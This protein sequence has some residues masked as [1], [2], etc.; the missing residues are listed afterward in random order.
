MPAAGL[1]QC[2]QTGALDALGTYPTPQDYVGETQFT[3]IPYKF[4]YCLRE[5][6]WLT[7][8][9]VPLL[10]KLIHDGEIAANKTNGWWM[11]RRNQLLRL[12]PAACH[13]TY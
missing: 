4:S 2:R 13:A 3:G 6:A 1:V 12:L 9:P 7:G 8:L 11:I 5:T 10:R